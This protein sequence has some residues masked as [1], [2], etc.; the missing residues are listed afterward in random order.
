MKLRNKKTGEIGRLYFDHQLID[1][2]PGTYAIVIQHK[3]ELGFEAFAN[4]FSLAKLNEDWEDYKPKEPYIGD[5]ATA[6]FVRAWAKHWEIDELVAHIYEGSLCLVG[7][8]EPRV[9]GRA[10]DILS[11]FVSGE[12]EEGGHY[13]IDDLCGEEEE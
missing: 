2:K 8:T 10:I 7:W 6:K 11:A 13:T 9:R 12:V 4:Y 1:P 5:E 3:D